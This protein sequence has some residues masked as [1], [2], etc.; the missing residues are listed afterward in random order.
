MSTPYQ[1]QF[2]YIGTRDYGPWC[3]F[4]DAID[5]REQQLGGEDRIRHYLKDLGSYALRTLTASWGTQ[6]AAPDAMTGGLLTVG[7]PIPSNWSSAAKS[8]CA[9]TISST[10]V[11]K[12]HMQRQHD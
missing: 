7:L 1:G 4:G 3:T 6:A 11:H 5:F 8:A 2:D 10:L 9:G 12:H